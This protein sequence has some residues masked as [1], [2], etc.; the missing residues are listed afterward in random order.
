VTT[1]PTPV[2]AASPGGA[3]SPAALLTK[4]A[5]V[6]YAV[7]AAASAG[8]LA[9]RGHAGVLR[10]DPAAPAARFGLAGDVA[11]DLAVGILL[12]LAIAAASEA[13]AR[14]AAMRFLSERLRELLLGLKPGQALLLALSS[15]IG[16]ELLFRG[17]MFSELEPRIGT[18]WTLAA[19]TRLFAAAHTGR[20]RRFL[21]WTAISLLVGLLLGG[22]RIATGSLLAPIALH[23]TVNAVNLVVESWDQR[24]PVDSRPR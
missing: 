24:L 1:S 11:L 6:F 20:D 14:T 19:T 22:L 21:V 17:I 15:G 18:G 2:G 13:P 8:A 16:E 12:G 10:P 4:T 5:L 9:W 3:G 7:I 23:V